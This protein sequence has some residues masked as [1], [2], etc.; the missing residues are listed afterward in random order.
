MPINVLDYR[1]SGVSGAFVQNFTVGAAGQLARV[2]LLVVNWPS[3]GGNLNLRVTTQQVSGLPNSTTLASA[4]VSFPQTLASRIRTRGR[5]PT[6]YESFEAPYPYKWSVRDWVGFYFTPFSVN[7]GDKLSLVFTGSQM[8][9]RPE[10]DQG[11]LGSEIYGSV[12]GSVGNAYWHEAP[13][14]YAQTSQAFRF[15]AFLSPAPEAFLPPF[16]YGDECELHPGM[17]NLQ[18]PARLKTL[19][20]PSVARARAV[21][22]SPEVVRG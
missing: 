20:V 17:A 3:T 13:D 15:R 12:V 9:D 11:P 5:G 22:V 18:L 1:W 4:S 2:D 6:Y 10:L 14:G 21:A 16:R 7:I 19:N 8:D